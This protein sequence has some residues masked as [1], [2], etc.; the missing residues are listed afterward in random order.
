MLF[1]G[2]VGLLRWILETIWYYL[3]LEHGAT[4]VQDMARPGWYLT[5]AAPFAVANIVT[6]CGRWVIFAFVPFALGAALGGK[7]RFRPFLNVYAA[8][9]GIYVVTI[10]INYVYLWVDIP[11]FQLGVSEVYRPNIGVGQIVTSLWLVWV[12]YHA[13]RILH[14]L[15]A[16][17]ALLVGFSLPV[18]NLSLPAVGAAILFRQPTMASANLQQRALVANGLFVLAV[19]AVI[20]VLL[21]LGNRIDRRIQRR[22]VTPE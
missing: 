6:A 13:G 9:L 4:L 11:F 17:S 14:G 19:L 8:A 16:A 1:L 10:L 21:W 12:T 5:I 15:D 2:C 20:P 3:S 18:L 22:C 7:A